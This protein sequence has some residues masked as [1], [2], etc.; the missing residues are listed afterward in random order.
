MFIAKAMALLLRQ[1]VGITQLAPRRCSPLATFSSATS[2]AHP[3]EIASQATAERRS[4]VALPREVEGT[5]ASRKLRRSGWIPSILYGGSGFGNRQLLQVETKALNK[6]LRE[7]KGSFNNTL[8]DLHVG[9][10]TYSVLPR[11]LQI[12]PATDRIQNLTFMAYEPGVHAVDIPLKVANE[13]RCVPIRRGAFFLQVSHKIKCKVEEGFEIPPF[14]EVDLTGA[15]NKEVLRISKVR[16]PEGVKFLVT[17]TNWC[18]GTV[19]GK[20]VRS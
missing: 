1:R 20:R 6:E 10:K 15:A 5:R 17:D 18:A 8:Y 4:F 19:V 14:L 16:R 9:E 11:Q 3:H 2:A 13:D 12:H 7:L